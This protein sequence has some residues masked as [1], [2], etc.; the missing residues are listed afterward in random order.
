MF[1]ECLA[2]LTSFC[3]QGIQMAQL[4]MLKRDCGNPN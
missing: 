1:V 4:G 2:E 3:V